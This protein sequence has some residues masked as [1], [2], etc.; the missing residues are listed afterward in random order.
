MTIVDILLWVFYHVDLEIQAMN[1]GRIRARGPD[2]KLHDSEVITIELVGELLGIDTDEQ[3]FQHFRRYHAAEFPTLRAVNRSSFVRQSANLW[4]IKQLLQQRFS[5]KL[6]FAQAG[7]QQELWLIDSFPLRVCRFK[8]APA[9]KLFTGYAAYGKDPT[10]GGSTGRFFG[11]RV[12]LRIND[13]GGCSALTLAPANIIDAQ[14]VPELAVPDGQGIADRAYWNPLIQDQLRRDPGFTLL[15]P[16]RKKSS[17]PWPQRSH[18]LSRLRQTIEVVIG[19]LAVRFHAQRTWAR[20]LWHLT[21]RLGRKILSHTLALF[22]NWLQGNPM[23][24]LDR[25]ISD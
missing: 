19:Q 6:P 3:I 10:D 20:D 23:L 7:C 11:F 24:Q 21:V 17:D 1:L 4:R 13:Q 16:F 18:L 2:P 14:L 9:H 12:H 25:L 15:A 5:G 22:I 8:R